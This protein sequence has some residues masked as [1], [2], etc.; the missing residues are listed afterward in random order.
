MTAGLSAANLAN[1]WLDMLGG[2][3]FTAPA[4]SF[5]LPHTGDPGSAGTANTIASVPRVAVT[6]NA[7]AGGSKTASNTPAWASW[8]FASPSV[9]THLSFWDAVT[10][11]NFLFSCS[12]ASAQTVVT[13][14]TLVANPVSI[15]F[16]PIAA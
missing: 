9:I 8:A 16:A 3:A 7:A 10:A 12:V 15:L 4:G 1:K 5:V 2:T 14:N 11:G 13:G 6:W